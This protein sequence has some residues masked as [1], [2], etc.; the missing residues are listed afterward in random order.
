MKFKNFFV[1]IILFKTFQISFGQDMYAPLNLEITDSSLVNIGLSWET[2]EA[3]RIQSITHLNGTPFTGVGNSDNSPVAYFQRFS[4]QMLSADQEHGKTIKSLRFYAFYQGSF[5][6]LVFMTSGT[7]SDTVPDIANLSNCVLSGPKITTPNTFAWN[8]VNLFNYN[9]MIED[10]SE[11]ST[12][13]IDTTMDV[14]FGFIISEYVAP[15]FPMGVD[16]GPA[17]DGYGNMLSILG[18]NNNTNSGYFSFGWMTLIENNS[19]LTF[20]WGIELNLISN[21]SLSSYKVYENSVEI[22]TITPGCDGS[23]YCTSESTD[24]GPRPQ[25]FHEYY[26]TSTYNGGESIASNIVSANI[27]NSPPGN[28]NLVEPEEG[29]IYQFSENEINESIRFIWRDSIDP[30]EQTLNYNVEICRENVCWDTTL[31]QNEDLLV[32]SFCRI[33]IPVQDLINNLN[34]EDNQNTILWSVYAS[35]GLDT[36]EVDDGFG[37]FSIN[38]DFLES[39]E[40]VYPTYFQLGNAY[41]NPFNPYTTLNY[42]L[43]IN[44]SVRLIIYDLVGNVIKSLVNKDESPGYKSVRWNATNKQG[45]PVSA[46]VYLY[47]FE[48]GDFVQ[49][50]KMILLK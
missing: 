21:N 25:G 42:Y 1:S 35:D 33:E 29:D 49:I 10:T 46:G 38:L 28:F 2:P 48:A 3:F 16:N 40:D 11:V 15:Q 5:Q 47:R 50:K 32:G 18:T 7:A 19:D 37:T 36:T 14:W 45:Q 44:A 4:G 27:S 39:Y 8:D 23:E 17:I 20:N 34:I 24:L 30:D 13:T 41:P 43:P 31:V 12:I 26:I 9:G 22:S 6:P